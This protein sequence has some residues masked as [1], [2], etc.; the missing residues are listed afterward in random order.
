M[1]K[2]LIT[3][4]DE[5]EALIALKHMTTKNIGRIIITNDGKITGIV[6]RTDILRAVRLLE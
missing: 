3:S 4:N 2:E 5:D 6:S 1:T